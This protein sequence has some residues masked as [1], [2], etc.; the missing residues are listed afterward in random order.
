MVLARTNYVTGNFATGTPT[1]SI[2]ILGE[3]KRVYVAGY[4]RYGQCG[5]GNT[6]NSAFWT[7]VSTSQGVPLENIT[8]VYAGGQKT[9][10]FFVALDENH[11]AWAWG[12]GPGGNFINGLFGIASNELLYATRIWDSSVRNRRANY[13]ITQTSGNVPGIS[14]QSVGQLD[15][16]G[17][18]IIAS[19]ENNAGGTI[20]KEFYRRNDAGSAIVQINHT[21]FNTTAYSIQELYHS[22]GPRLIGWSAMRQ[23]RSENNF[24]YVLA[25]N[26]NTNMLELWSSGSNF[27]HRGHAT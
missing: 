10:T 7:T 26:K 3:D 4:G 23:Q 16:D 15:V 12:Y 27:S 8:K 5:D 2:A 18:L 11:D 17:T 21:V 1:E 14:G 13:V 19:H 9:G 6:T 25:R 20:D 22:N 24:Y